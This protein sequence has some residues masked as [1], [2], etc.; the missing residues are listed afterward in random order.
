MLSRNVTPVAPV[1]GGCHPKQTGLSLNI[2]SS[3]HSRVFIQLLIQCM[4]ES[5]RTFSFIKLLP[6]A[7]SARATAGRI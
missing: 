4:Y 6:R 5:Q 2:C 3:K 7:S 1:G